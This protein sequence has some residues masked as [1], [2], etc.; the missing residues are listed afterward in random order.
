MTI[1]VIED[2][3]KISEFLK[4]VLEINPNN[5]AIIYELS[6]CYE[7]ANKPDKSVAFYKNFIDKNFGKSVKIDWNVYFEGRKS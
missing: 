4:K 7:L 6:F 2:E 3:K 5:E 1:L